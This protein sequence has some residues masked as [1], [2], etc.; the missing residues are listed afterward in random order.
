MLTSLGTQKIDIGHRKEVRGR[1][2]D[3]WDIFTPKSCFFMRVTSVYASRGLCNLYV[4][5][6][7]ESF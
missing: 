6:I 4:K 5:Y 2:S 7:L 3:L 1:V